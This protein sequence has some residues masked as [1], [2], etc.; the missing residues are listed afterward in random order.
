[1]VFKLKDTQ[2]A[3]RP[4]WVLAFTILGHPEQ[5]SLQE[6]PANPSRHINTEARASA[7]LLEL[8]PESQAHD[9]G[10]GEWSDSQDTLAPS[11]TRAAIPKGLLDTQGR[12]ETSAFPLEASDLTEHTACLAAPSHR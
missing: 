1:M 5:R 6:H 2:P 11:P 3:Q 8:G 12:K 7:A 4:R 9:G 10:D